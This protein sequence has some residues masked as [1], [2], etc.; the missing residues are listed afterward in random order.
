[1]SY[2]FQ[3]KCEKIS[4]NKFR[5]YFKN[6]NIVCLEE[7][8]ADEKFDIKTWPQEGL[9]FS[10]LENTCRAIELNYSSDTKV[11]NVRILSASSY[12]DFD[13][14]LSIILYFAENF[15]S[16]RVNKPILYET[17]KKYSIKEFKD[18]YNQNWIKKSLEFDTNALL[19]LVQDREI[20]IIGT[21]RSMYFGSKTFEKYQMLSTE[22]GIDFAEFY[23]SQMSKLQTIEFDN[24][25]YT[26]IWD[27]DRDPN[28][29]KK[30]LIML[31]ENMPLMLPPSDLVLIPKQIKEQSFLIHRKELEEVLKLSNIPFEYFDDQNVKIGEIKSLNDLIIS[32]KLKVKF[33]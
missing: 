12:Q 3:V 24:I 15:K 33:I 8:S 20:E 31:Q 25:Y 22:K 26:S 21:R 23:F 16:S 10:P 29:G 28:I 4:Y 32:D 17:T 9:R 6:H 5:E 18:E 19:S 2:D 14:A 27:Y 13:L 7:E 11:M 30:T 1:M